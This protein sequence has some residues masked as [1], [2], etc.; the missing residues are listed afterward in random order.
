MIR[1]QKNRREINTAGPWRTGYQQ[2]GFQDCEGG[3][4][5]F[6]RLLFSR[7]RAYLPGS[8]RENCCTPIFQGTFSTLQKGV[9]PAR[10]DREETLFPANVCSGRNA[11][12][13]SASGLKGPMVG[14]CS[15]ES[16]SAGPFPLPLVQGSC[17]LSRMKY[18]FWTTTAGSSNLSSP[19][20]ILEVWHPE[21]E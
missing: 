15:R 5:C 6:S 12:L 10:R 2:A 20:N 13:E 7:R 18:S 17:Y 21:R 16:I 8:T 11:S 3:Y 14:R 9:F 4:R 19:V 1:L